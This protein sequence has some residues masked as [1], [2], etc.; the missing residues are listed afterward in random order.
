MFAFHQWVSPKLVDSGGVELVWTHKWGINSSWSVPARKLVAHQLCFEHSLPSEHIC[1]PSQMCTPYTTTPT[2]SLET[3]YTQERY[4]VCCQLLKKERSRPPKYLT[5]T[6]Y[7]VS[8]HGRGGS[9]GQS[10]HA[11]RYNR[12]TIPPCDG[13]AQDHPADHTL[14]GRYLFVRSRLLL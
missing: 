9:H 11:A 5:H 3:A 1:K 2:S 13:D 8:I 12:H 10:P 6:M 7:F 4:Q 14:K